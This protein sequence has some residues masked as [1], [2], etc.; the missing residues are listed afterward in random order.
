MASVVK[1]DHKAIV[2]Y[3]DKL[4]CPQLKKTALQ[5]TF[6]LTTPTQ[7]EMFLQHITVTEE[8]NL[9]LFNNSS[10]SWSDTQIEF[11]AFYKTALSLLNQFY[12]ERTI[13]VT[14]RD[15][16]FI[17]P[18]IKAKLRRKNILM[19]AGRVE[20][21]GA[22]AERI[23]KDMTRRGKTRL[24]RINRKTDAKD[25]WAAVRQTDSNFITQMLFTD[26]Y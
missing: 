13:T 26:I 12:P 22:L 10:Q 4:Q 11:D 18:E 24:C 8:N 15:P 14:S 1:S 7:H 25:L 21:D 16:Q 6:R 5:C 20:E 2:V 23:G 19:H 3:A 17:T 9:L